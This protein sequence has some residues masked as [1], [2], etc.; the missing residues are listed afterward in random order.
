M[1]SL[2]YILLFS[3]LLSLIYPI[4]LLTTKGFGYILY[5]LILVI[6]FFIIIFLLS[7][8]IFYFDKKEMEY[9]LRISFI[10]GICYITAKYINA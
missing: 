1:M 7:F 3:F 2:E 9:F 6:V 4:F 8:S 5:S 10:I